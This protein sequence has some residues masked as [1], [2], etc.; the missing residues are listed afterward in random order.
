MIKFR[1]SLRQLLRRRFVQSALWIL[2]FVAVWQTVCELG[3]VPAFFLPKFTKVLSTLFGELLGGALGRQV[4]TSISM[5]LLGFLVSFAVVA[6]MVVLSIWSKAFRS[7]FL[8]FMTILNP[9]PSMALMPLIILWF[10]ID[11]TAMLVLII[12]GVVWSMYRHIWDGITSIPKVYS[13]FAENIE[14]R[15][16]QRIFGIVLFAIMPEI[17]ASLRIAW[18]RSWRALISA[19]IAFG[20]IGELGGVG[21]YISMGRVYGRMDRVIAG[22]LVIAAV[23]VLVEVLLFDRIVK[24]TVRKWGMVNE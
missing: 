4:L 24:R 19:E 12:H 6:V 2:L 13:E 7:L 21:Y 17:V 14:L 3:L 8:T 16:T 1:N 11:T 23:G 20:A 18:G 9:L 15:L 22:V 5:V 10:G